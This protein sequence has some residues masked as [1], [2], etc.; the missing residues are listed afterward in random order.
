MSIGERTAENTGAEMAQLEDAVEQENSFLP[1][2]E[3]E[4]ITPAKEPCS[5]KVAIDQDCTLYLDRNADGQY[6]LYISYSHGRHINCASLDDAKAILLT[7]LL[8]HL[9][10]TVKQLREICG[11]IEKM[12]KESI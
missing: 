1:A 2:L 10:A 7:V 4:D 6:W 5:W 9:E 8:P 12:S 11:Q 3:W